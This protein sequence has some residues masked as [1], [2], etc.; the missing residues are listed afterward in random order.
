MEILLK[1]N[2]KSFIRLFVHKSK[3]KTSNVLIN[4]HGLYGMS[5]DPGS[6][7]E[8]LAGEVA[9]KGL[10]HAVIFN[11]SRDWNAFEDGNWEKMKKA[12]ADKTFTQELQD[13]KDTIGL[14]IDQSEY[15]FGA[16]KDKLRIF[17]VGNSLGGTLVTCLDDY[18]KYIDKIV[19]AGSGTRTVFPSNLTEKKVLSKAGKFKGKVM[20]LQGSKNNVVPL[21]AGDT[22]LSGYKNAETTK[23][24]IEGANHNFSKI[25]GKN[26]TLAYKLYLDSIVKFL[27]NKT[28]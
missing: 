12:F 3:K 4:V 24:V 28:K 14:I 23:K 27:Q 9:S 13:I 25:N 16:K 20:F 10:A 2:F 21:G 5:G 17:L 11:S 15:L 8:M 18:F 26:K 19:L 7:S 22:L 1:G 6:K